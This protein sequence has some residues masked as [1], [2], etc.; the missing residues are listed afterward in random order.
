[1]SRFFAFTKSLSKVKYC[2]VN[3]TKDLIV[4]LKLTVPAKAHVAQQTVHSWVKMRSAA[5]SLSV[6]M[7]AHAM[8]PLPCARLQNQRRTT[9]LAMQRR[10]SASTGY[11]SLTCS[12]LRLLSKEPLRKRFS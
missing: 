4:C 1:M 12:L 7:R 10:K 6:P 5:R 2:V 9:L 11:G 3:S 8:E